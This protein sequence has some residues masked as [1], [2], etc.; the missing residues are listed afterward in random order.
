MEPI[1]I[2]GAG[3]AG[4]LASS[5]AAE[6]GTRV[7]LL[8]RNAR[9][10]IKVRIS[11]GGKCNITHAGT[12]E[13]VRSAFLP[14]EAR[15]LRP[16]FHRFTNQDIRARLERQG[17][18][19][20]AREDGRVFPVSGR[21]ADVVEALARPLH[22][23]G[24]EIRLNT[25]VESITADAD[26]ITGVQTAVGPIVGRRVI[27]AT[28][29]ASY[30]KTGTTGD[31][32][33]WAGAL[34]HTI[35]PI[36]PALAPIIL[37]PP[38]PGEWRGIAVRNGSLT[39]STQGKPQASQRGDILFTHEGISGPATLAVSRDAAFHLES[40]PVDVTFDFFPER[41]HA[42]LDADLIRLT[43]SHGARTLQTILAEWLPNRMVPWLLAQAGVRPE[44]RGLALTR[45]HRRA[46]VGLLKNWQMG[47]VASIPLDR[48]EV[49]SGGVSLDEVDPQTMHSRKVRGLFLCGEVLDIA[50][51]VGGYNLQ[52]AFSTG[53]VAGESAALELI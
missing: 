21:A 30:A 40:G 19:T 12:M 7:L 39:V 33:R 25:S 29:G 11:G 9:P 43:R 3:G 47:S 44:V 38:L 23:L 8:E 14:R 15:F 20:F 4:L 2:I 37:S 1:I 52:A 17:V 46:L 32:F 35:V 13:D 10:G 42:A 45:G 50:G 41:D 36:R 6:C 48:G 27:L 18:P 51:P 31:G 24:V 49:S 26:G 28:G 34:G 22:T 16:S 53:F 5:R